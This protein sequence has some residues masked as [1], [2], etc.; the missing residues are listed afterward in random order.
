MTRVAFLL[1]PVTMLEEI[2]KGNFRL[3][4]PEEKKEEKKVK[5]GNKTFVYFLSKLGPTSDRAS[6]GEVGACQ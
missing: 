3:K 4:K 1:D 5:D 2:K 6:A